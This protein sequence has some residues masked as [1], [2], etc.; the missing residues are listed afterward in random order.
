M[1]GAAKMTLDLKE[2]KKANSA[3]GQHQRTIW[4]KTHYVLM[5][6]I[7][8]IIS[9]IL[10]AIGWVFFIVLYPIFWVLNNRE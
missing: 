8:W 4:D 10:I 7:D 6:V 3:K 9:A 5:T 1:P 2:N